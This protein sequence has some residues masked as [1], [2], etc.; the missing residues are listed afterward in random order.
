MC[1]LILSYYTRKKEHKN[2]QEGKRKQLLSSKITTKI[3]IYMYIYILIEMTNIL[4]LIQKILSQF[5]F[6]FNWVIVYM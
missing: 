2:K 5:W 6:V 3:W 1:P 4:A